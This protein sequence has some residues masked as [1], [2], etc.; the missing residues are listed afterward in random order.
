MVGFK[1]DSEKKLKETGDSYLL[2]FGCDVDRISPSMFFGTRLCE[3]YQKYV[4]SNR[5]LADEGKHSLMQDID[6][7]HT[8]FY[9][10]QNLFFIDVA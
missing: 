10:T 6:E 4:L 1:G 7:F 2:Y 8:W 3:R 5:V 9:I